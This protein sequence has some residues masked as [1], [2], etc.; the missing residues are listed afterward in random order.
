MS[1]V[2]SLLWVGWRARV[3]LIRSLRR[4]MFAGHAQLDPAATLLE[5][6][7]VV[8]LRG[9][10]SAVRVGAR[11]VVGGELLVFA[12]GGRVEIGEWCFV[13]EGS[14]IWSANEVVI[15]SRVLISHGVNIHDCDSHPRD[16][17]ERHR[18]FRELC[19]NGHPRELR[20]VPNAPVRI[21]DDAWIGFNATILKGVTIGARCIVAAGS[22]VT[23]DVPPDS[24]HIADA[25]AGRV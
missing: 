15:G 5:T 20:S 2:S 10:R 6:A 18:H 9:D 12:H 4:A 8:N 1:M 13:G 23:R 16:A 24:I 14:R 19:E 3:R 7:R 11:S 22:I 25:V 17:A 21:G